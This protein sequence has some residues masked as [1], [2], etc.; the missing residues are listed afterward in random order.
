VDPD[1]CH[2]GFGGDSERSDRNGPTSNL[3]VS[4]ILFVSFLSHSKNNITIKIII[5][6]KF[7]NYQL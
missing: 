7:N 5:R 6:L 3:E 1:S 4:F 2:V